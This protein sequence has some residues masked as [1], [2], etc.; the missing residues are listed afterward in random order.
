MADHGVMDP[1]SIIL[2]LVL[3]SAVSAFIAV[4]AARR[5]DGGSRLFRSTDRRSLLVGGLVMLVAI[6]GTALLVLGR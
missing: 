1:V 3:A 5:E 2:L 6:V 4:R